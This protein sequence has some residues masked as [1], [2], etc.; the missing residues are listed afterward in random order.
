MSKVVLKNLV[1]SYDG[2]KNIIDN[3]DLEIKYVDGTQKTFLD[4]EDVSERI[5]E[6][7]VSMAASNISLSTPS[8]KPK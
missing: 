5:R 7:H 1:K 4:K 8:L 2:V 6:P 3:I